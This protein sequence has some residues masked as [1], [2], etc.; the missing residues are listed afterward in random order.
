MHI[1]VNTVGKAMLLSLCGLAAGVINGLLGAG[2]G[3]LI[4]FALHAVLGSALGDTRDVFAN[5]TAV[6][7]PI[8]LFSVLSYFLSGGLTGAAVLSPYLLPGAL[9]GF[10]GAYLLGRLP[11]SVIKGIFGLVVTVS[12]LILLIR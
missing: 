7:L 1:K 12:G 2:S 8:S 3:V 9:G 10:L 4:V 5:A 6:I 11:E